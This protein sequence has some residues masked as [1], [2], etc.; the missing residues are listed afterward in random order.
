MNKKAPEK[1][2]FLVQ[3]LFHVDPCAIPFI[4]D[5]QLKNESHHPS[6]FI[7]FCGLHIIDYRKNTTDA[8]PGVQPT[9]V[10]NFLSVFNKP[11]KIQVCFRH[12]QKPTV[13]NFYLRCYDVPPTRNSFDNLFCVRL[14]DKHSW[15]EKQNEPWVRVR[16]LKDGKKIIFAITNRERSLMVHQVLL[17]QNSIQPV[18]ASNISFQS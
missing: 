10:Q 2:I 7:N 13:D 11:A 9:R 14:L 18:I 12:P 15:F 4:S 3:S 5:F 1:I 17:L 6:V 16:K 8:F